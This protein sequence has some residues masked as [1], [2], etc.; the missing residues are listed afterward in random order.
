[1]RIQP[2]STVEVQHTHRRMSMIADFHVILTKNCHLIQR[3]RQGHLVPLL[4]VVDSHA[5]V[6]SSAIDR[7]VALQSR[8]GLIRSIERC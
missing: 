4:V 5:D 7:K 1:M 3:P 6:M 8:L 2:L